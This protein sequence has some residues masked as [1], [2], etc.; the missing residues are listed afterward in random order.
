MQRGSGLH[1]AKY[2]EA[3]GLGYAAEANARLIAAAPD[4]LEAIEDLGRGQTVERLASAYHAIA[5]ARG[6]A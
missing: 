1:I 2:E 5:K 6:E 3:P 4:L